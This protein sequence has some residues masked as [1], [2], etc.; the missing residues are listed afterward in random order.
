MYTEQRETGKAENKFV[1]VPLVQPR[2]PE[3][4]QG[5]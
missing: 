1:H 3:D 4:F 2:D 5:L